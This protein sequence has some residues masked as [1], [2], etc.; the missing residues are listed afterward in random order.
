MTEYG[1]RL[2]PNPR[3]A[4]P[5]PV[6]TGTEREQRRKRIVWRALGPARG[7]R[8]ANS[9]H[10]CHYWLYHPMEHPLTPSLKDGLRIC[11]DNPFLRG[12]PNADAGT[13]SALGIPLIVSGTEATPG[14]SVDAREW[15]TVRLSFLNACGFVSHPEEDMELQTPPLH[16]FLTYKLETAGEND[17]LKAS[18]YGNF[19]STLYQ[20]RQL[21]LRDV[22]SPLPGTEES[23][24][25]PCLSLLYSG[26]TFDNFGWRNPEP[27]EQSKYS[28]TDRFGLK[29]SDPSVE[30]VIANDLRNAVLRGF[31]SGERRNKAM[32]QTITLSR[33]VGGDPCL[34]TFALEGFNNHRDTRGLACFGIKVRLNEFQELVRDGH[35]GALPLSNLGFNMRLDLYEVYPPK[36]PHIALIQIYAALCYR[37]VGRVLGCR[38]YDL[39]G[40]KHERD[41]KPLVRAVLEL[42]SYK[43]RALGETIAYAVKV[44][45]PADVAFAQEMKRE[46]QAI[47]E[48]HDKEYKTNYSA[49]KY[50]EGW[51]NALPL[52][53]SPERLALLSQSVVIRALLY[54]MMAW[55]RGEEITDQH[56][57]EVRQ[58]VARWKREHGVPSPPE[59]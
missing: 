12:Y 1:P 13:G 36:R 43:I 48:E 46:F 41:Q 56:V 8:L 11:R 26:L 30:H 57:D 51:T 34:W 38:A 16:L 53:G 7:D 10:A 18:G 45:C 59:A 33:K 44:L 21:I 17:V 58:T 50:P 32:W 6:F 4:P 40:P 20:V 22:W 9:L 29:G 15:D 35:I 25:W 47:G 14:T 2:P 27:G 19:G 39:G 23:V 31:V 37:G 3:P 55:P 5:W 52:M 49:S 28:F 24:N 54:E 42:K